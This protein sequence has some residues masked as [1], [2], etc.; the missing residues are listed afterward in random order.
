MARGEPGVYASI[1]T[2]QERQLA[3]DHGYNAPNTTRSPGTPEPT[4]LWHWPPDDEL[5]RILAGAAGVKIDP[6]NKTEG[7]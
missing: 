3:A 7:G 2:D 1:P 4:K 5:K 6:S